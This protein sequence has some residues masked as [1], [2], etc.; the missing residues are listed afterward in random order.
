LAWAAQTPATSVA[1]ECSSVLFQ[2]GIFKT[3]LKQVFQFEV[4]FDLVT[5]IKGVLKVL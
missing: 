4:L 5:H 2:R 1:P 3:L